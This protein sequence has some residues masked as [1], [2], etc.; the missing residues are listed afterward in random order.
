VI[1]VCSHHLGTPPVPPSA[2][3]GYAVP[4]SISRIVLACMEKTPDRRPA[5]ARALV[6]MLD[7]CSDMEPWT[8]DVARTWWRVQGP[9]VLAQRQRSHTAGGDDHPSLL[10]AAAALV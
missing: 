1:E 4:D 8:A 6:E 2:R 3:L 7:D 9:L 10:T 5:S